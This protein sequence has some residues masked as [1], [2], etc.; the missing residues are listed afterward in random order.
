MRRMTLSALVGLLPLFLPSPVA[1][2]TGASP[3]DPVVVTAR[4]L[5]ER[6]QTLRW[7]GA[8]SGYPPSDEPLARMTEPLCVAASGLSAKAGAPIADRI[9]G[10]AERL[11]I[12]LGGEKCSP[13][14]L[15]LIV[16]NGASQVAWLADHRPSAFGNMSA[17]DV[18]E[19]VRDKG[20]V[21]SWSL[22]AITSRDGDPLVQ[23]GGG[24]PTLRIPTAS[25]ISLSTKSHIAAAILLI[26]R[27][28]VEGK[29]INQIADY[30]TM[31]LLAE[32]RPRKAEGVSTIL[33]LFDPDGGAPEA[34]TPFDWG[35]LR[36]LYSGQGDRA[37]AFQYAAMARFVEQD[38]AAGDPKP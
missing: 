7:F 9:L 4:R 12:R 25:R 10:H 38:L 31:R 1:A 14:V 15:L 13:N 26:D 24:L 29:T 3:S 27:A 22:T 37:P 21:H 19:L 16:E 17:H 32:V 20:P 36:G 6:R 8:I 33:S 5:P 11:G 18:G 2:Q 35:Y 30:A 28:A 34:L 23:I